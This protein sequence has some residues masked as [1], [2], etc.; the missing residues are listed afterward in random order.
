MF[1]AMLVG[2]LLFTMDEVAASAAELWQYGG[3]VDVSY[4]HNPSH[5]E[6]HHWRSNE[7]SVSTNELA[8]TMGLLYLRKDP[9]EQSRWGMELALQAGYDTDALVPEPTADGTRPVSGADTPRHIARANV[10]YL[11][12]IGRGVTFSA[13]LMKGSKTYEELSAKYNVNYTRAC[14]TDYNPNFVMGFGTSDPVSK[15]L[16][17]GVYVIN[18]Y[19]H[20]AHAHDAP[21]C[22]SKMEWRV[23]G[24]LTLYENFYYGPDQRAT[25]VDYWRTFSDSTVEWRKPDWRVALS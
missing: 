23:S 10:S 16:E 1:L 18:G 25:S 12:P 8:S 9:A 7:T 20:L 5:P 19:R 24:H 13:G 22:M 4:A 11:A 21:S 17:L 2:G 15:S 14:I 3:F 6:N